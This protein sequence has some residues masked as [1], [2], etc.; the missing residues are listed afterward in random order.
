MLSLM[1]ESRGD[2]VSASSVAIVP[3]RGL[4]LSRDQ[5]RQETINQGFEGHVKNTD[6][7]TLDLNQASDRQARNSSKTVPGS[8]G[9]LLQTIE[10]IEAKQIEFG[11]DSPQKDHTKST[12]KIEEN[13]FMNFNF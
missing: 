3:A 2:A 5:T 1:A 7:E 11:R 10:P 6:D 4:M 13:I 9:T 12:S 8:H